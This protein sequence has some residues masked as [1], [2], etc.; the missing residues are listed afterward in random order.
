MKAS[1]LFQELRVNL[2][3]S[4]LVHGAEL[5]A[6]AAGATLADTLALPNNPFFQVGS[7][8]MAVV[9]FATTDTAANLIQIA[10]RNAGNTADIELDDAGSGPAGQA[11][12]GLAVAIFSLTAVGERIQVRNKNAGTAALFYQASV[13]IFAFPA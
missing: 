3:P 8:V 6:P 7:L 2:P 4:V 9:S 13:Y 11:G 5:T 1:A 10:H 12:E